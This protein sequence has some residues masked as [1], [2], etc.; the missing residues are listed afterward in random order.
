MTKPEWLEGLRY[1]QMSPINDDRGSFSEVWRKHS[2]DRP[3]VQD[4]FLQSKKHVLRGLHCTVYP[5]SGKFVSVLK[6]RIF[7]VAV[8]LRPDSKTFGRWYGRELSA[9]NQL[10]AWIP[11]GCAH[12]F[13]SIS[14]SL[15][16]Y[17][18][19]REYIPHEERG[20]RWDDEELGIKWPIKGQP[21]LSDKD[22]TSAKLVTWR[23]YGYLGGSSAS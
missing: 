19:T 6:G 22:K 10:Q 21:I 12:G 17:K 11:P 4:N 2:F 13:L 14:D 1:S 23:Q 7:D 16:M 20:L 8:D 3:F 5:G 9:G 18:S 15:V